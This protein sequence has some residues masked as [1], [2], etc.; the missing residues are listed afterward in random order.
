[1]Y[2][3]IDILVTT[4]G[5]Q[6][7][8]EK[9]RGFFGRM[10]KAERPKLEITM[11]FI[12][13]IVAGLLLVGVVWIGYY[14][15][16]GQTNRYTDKEVNA[17]TVTESAVEIDEEE[18]IEPVET[19]A[20]DGDMIINED[21]VFDN[22]AELKDATEAYTTSD[23]NLRSEA[24]LTAPVLL[25]VPISTLVNIVE[26]D[27]EGEWVK[28]S[29]NG[30]EGYINAMYLSV[31]KPTP[32]VY[33][34]P[35]A[36]VVSTPKPTKKPKPTKAPEETPAPDETEEPDYTEEPTFTEEPVMTD[37]PVET[38]QPAPTEAPPAPT[39][40]P[41]APTEAPPAPTEAPLPEPTVP[42]V[43]E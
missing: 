11:F 10:L 6:T 40:A 4:I 21:N 29:Y 26:Y 3:S 15:I 33:Y 42:P 39:E 5:E 1:M 30:T 12:S 23:V 34:D 8:M 16:K 28:V 43:S 7:D 38:E 35:V 41:P 22:T 14:Y 9:K 20:P 37:T 31:D 25:K 18:E 27:G 19:I 32:V 24:S 36:P 17:G 13:I 2:N